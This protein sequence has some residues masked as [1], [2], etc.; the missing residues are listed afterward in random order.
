VAAAGQLEL[1]LELELAEVLALVQA[2][3]VEVVVEVESQKTA[4]FTELVLAAF[5]E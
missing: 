4:G 5:L 2:G 1:E 3:L